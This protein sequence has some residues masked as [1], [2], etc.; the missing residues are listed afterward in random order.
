M[1]FSLCMKKLVMGIIFAT[2]F[3]GFAAAHDVVVSE[4]NSTFFS[5][6]VR[7][8]RDMYAYEVNF[9]VDGDIERINHQDF[10]DV[11]GENTEPVYD[12]N[13]RDGFLSVYGTRLDDV[14][15][16]VSGDGNLFTV[17]YRGNLLLHSSLQVDSS[18]NEE[19]VFYDLGG[20]DDGGAGSPG[21]A[22]RALG[23]GV[24]GSSENRAGSVKSVVR[25]ANISSAAV[26]RSDTEA[27]SDAENKSEGRK[28]ITGS[29]IEMDQNNWGLLNSRLILLFIGFVV[30]SF[31]VM[32]I[33]FRYR[34]MEKSDKSL[35][36][37]R[38]MQ[39]NKEL[40]KLGKELRGR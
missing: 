38:T 25:E 24:A 11:G 39:L 9:I 5:V 6:S 1:F 7:N 4:L 34:K 37:G 30:V 18:G 2:L 13:E 36:V 23:G 29:S 21:S 10:L 14:R 31:V 40:Q 12:F 16:G 8:A 20:V 22:G 33:I 15:R 3:F 26:N 28:G 17:R 32:N 35:E 27:P 19:Y